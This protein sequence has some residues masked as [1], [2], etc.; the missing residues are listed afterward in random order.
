MR[1][2]RSLGICVPALFVCLHAFAQVQPRAHYADGQVWIVWDIDTNNIPDTYGIY[3]A[4]ASFTNTAQAKLIG[5][6]FP[7]DTRA[8]ILK[9][10]METAYGYSPLTGFKI[11]TAGGA[12]YTL[13]GLENLFVDTVRANGSAFYAVV[14]FGQ[15]NVSTTEITSHAISFTF[16]ANDPPQP[17][18]QVRTNSTT[19]HMVSFFTVWVDGDQDETAGRPDFPIMANASRRGVPHNFLIVE[20]HEG[21]PGSGPWPGMV[22]LHG[23]NGS[24]IEW[25]PS[26]DG[27]RSINVVPTDGVVIAFDDEL[28]RVLDV[29]TGAVSVTTGHLGYAREYNPYHPT[30]LSPDSVVINYTQRRDVWALDW[31]VAHANL[32]GHRISL[33]GHSN[34]AQGAMMLMKAYP[35]HFSS[36]ELF[37][38]TMR[39]Y[40]DAS[41]ISIYGTETQN[42]PTS[43]TN[44]LGEPVH[45]LDL[46]RFA[47]NTS[48][49]RD[50]PLLRHYA[51]KCDDNNHRQW[52]PEMLE[53]MRW[54]DELGIGLHFY[55]DMKSHGFDTWIDYWV[56]ATSTATLLNQMQRDDVRN[57]SRYRNNQSFPAFFNLQHYPN[58]GDPGPGYLG[59]STVDSQCGLA[60]DDTGNLVDNGDDHGTW[61]GYFDWDTLTIVDTTNTWACTMFLVS[62]NSGYADVDACPYTALSTDFALRRPQKFKPATGS[63]VS[64]ELQDATDGTV[65]HSGASIV[66]AEGLVTV[67]N[68]SIPRDPDRVRLVLT[69]GAAQPD[70]IVGTNGTGSLSVEWTGNPG[71]SVQLE[72]SLNLAD[73]FQLDLPAPEADNLMALEIPAYLLNDSKHFFRLR[74]DPLITTPIPTAPGF[75]TDLHFVHD[76]IARN[77]FLKIPSGWNTATNWPLVLVLPGHGQS[78][79]EFVSNQTELLG[80]ADSEGWILAFPE[81]TSGTGSYLWF[82]YDNPQLTQPYVDDAAFLFDLVNELKSSGLNINTNRIYASGFS[83]GGSMVHYLAGKTNHPFA[84]FAIM[85]SGTQPVTFYREP[86]DRNAPDSGAAVV[87]NVPMPWQ[88]RPALLM[89]MATSIPWPFEGRQYATN[90]ISR[91]A[92]QN[93]ARWTEANGFGSIPQTAPDWPL[94]PVPLLSLTTNW[95]AVGTDRA[96]VAYNDV[97]PDH[98]WPTNLVA[99]GW[100]L[101]DALRF[102][103]VTLIGTN[104]VDQ[105]LPQWVRDTYPHAVSPD[106]LAPTSLVRVDSGTMTVETWRTALN[107]RTNEVIFVG[108]SDGGHQWPNAADKLPFDACKEVLRFFSQH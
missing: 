42:L 44:R 33:L 13:S 16:D 76:S 102:P 35:E 68:L 56:D 83:N 64:W 88:P 47:T 20:P 57:Q 84:A 74:R 27:P 26:N 55:W 10:E 9:S 105:R 5:R 72:H 49:V 90:F 59:G 63:W 77:Y 107:N 32:D 81:A 34:G 73:W 30:L 8:G 3:S 93:L 100:S 12:T 6:V 75:Y 71:Y 31:L 2:C 97:R 7:A 95:T 40:N 85:E 53:Q 43:L 61:G 39:Q 21:L 38:C 14:P 104:I 45:M 98:D 69:A 4:A 99:T 94:P 106:P 87:A 23:G 22:C 101:D 15:T 25:L 62:S 29:N 48:T 86:Y 46:T 41:F 108:L 66:G 60:R 67:T 89:N 51:G 103:Y 82:A 18:L 70:L 92:R 50:W 37:N 17:H 80:L 52:G 65:F 28:Y 78:I 91:G 96:R 79:T 11:P 1:L 58:H 54:S 24:S 19:G 36:V